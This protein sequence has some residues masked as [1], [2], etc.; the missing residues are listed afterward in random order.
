GVPDEHFRN[1][2]Q[3][4][5]AAD[6]LVRAG[7]ASDRLFAWQ[8]ARRHYD[9]AL[10]ALGHLPD[11]DGNRRRRVDVLIKRASTSI[12]ADPPERNVERLAEADTLM[13][14]LADGTNGADDRRRLA[15]I[16]QWAG[17]AQHFNGNPRAAA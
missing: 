14:S 5:K 4:D 1:G 12:S 17:W 16:S 6:Y 10:A 15:W 3:W 13:Q 11:S 7:D 2:E 8:E 9:E